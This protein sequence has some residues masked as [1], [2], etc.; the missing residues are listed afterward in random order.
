MTTRNKHKTL[1]KKTQSLNRSIANFALFRALAKNKRAVSAVISNLILIGA[2]LAIGLVALGYARSTSIN[3]QTDYSKTMSSDIAKLKE[4]LIFEYA[5]YDGSNNLFLYVMNSGP[6]NVTVKTVSVNT[7]PVP[8]SSMTLYQ[9][10]DNQQISNGVIAKGT[11]VKVVLNT[12]GMTHS[13]ENSVKITSGS[14]SNFAYN[15][16]V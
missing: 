10:S 11:E 16:F 15:F 7:S 2:V 8:S 3:Y 4:T 9:M 1:R 5:H 6:V 14:D 12:A 13:G